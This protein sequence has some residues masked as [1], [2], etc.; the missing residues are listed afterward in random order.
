MLIIRTAE[1]R[2]V[3]ISRGN[4]WV[5]CDIRQ[6][7]MRLFDS[8]QE[9]VRVPLKIGMQRSRSTLRR[10]HDEKIWTF[11]DWHFPPEIALA[12][13][14]VRTSD[15]SAQLPAYSISSAQ[16]SILTKSLTLAPSSPKIIP[17][18]NFASGSISNRLSE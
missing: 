16:C 2:V 7:E 1:Q 17:S 14:E 12:A 3:F 9:N 5:P 4:P 10:T 13:I 18:L 6:I 11:Q 8:R 15:T